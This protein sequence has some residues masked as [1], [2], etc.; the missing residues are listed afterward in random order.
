[1]TIPFWHANISGS[2]DL[3]D[4]WTW[5]NHWGHPG[6]S[7]YYLTGP[8]GFRAQVKEA[9]AWMPTV[10]KL[11][12]DHIKDQERAARRAAHGGRKVL[13]FQCRTR[14]G[15]TWSPDP[16]GVPIPSSWRHEGSARYHVHTVQEA[17]AS[18]WLVEVEGEWPGS[19]ELLA[20]AKVSHAAA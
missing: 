5:G 17:V 1:M 19:T 6:A 4:G 14:T 7:G 11:I 18:G 3:P 9:G 13:T 20:A 16:D 15:L 10:G 12:E 2:T 8:A